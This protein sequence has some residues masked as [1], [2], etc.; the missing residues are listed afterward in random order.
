MIVTINGQIPS[1]LSAKNN[2]LE[3]DIVMI[4]FVP[5]GAGLAMITP[6]S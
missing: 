3:E 1:E 6:F 5:N 2:V 4:K